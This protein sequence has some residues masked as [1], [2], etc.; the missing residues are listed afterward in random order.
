LS[1]YMLLFLAIT[2]IVSQG[3][4]YDPAGLLG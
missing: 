4:V 1:G 2:R 3:V